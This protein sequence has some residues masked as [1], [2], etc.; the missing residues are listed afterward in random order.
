VITGK[1]SRCE[2]AKDGG[3][4][5]RI[6]SSLEPPLS[7]NRRCN[8]GLDDVEEHLQERSHHL[9]RIPK[10]DI[11][12]EFFPFILNRLPCENPTSAKLDFADV[13]Y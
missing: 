7:W 9:T 12:N 11:R 2:F 3:F 10:F 4:E 5:K 6:I 13:N 1:I 8:P